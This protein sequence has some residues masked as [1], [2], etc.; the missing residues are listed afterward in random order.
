MKQ[1]SNQAIKNWHQPK[2]VLFIFLVFML[3]LIV[4]LSYLSLSDTIYGNDLRAFAENRATVT[5]VLP[6][7]RGTIYDASG[8]PLALNVTSYTLYAYLEPS[9]TTNPDRPN[10]VV[11]IERT[12]SELGELIGAPYEYML[13]RLTA[14]AYQV[15][16]GPFGSRLTEL[17]MLSIKALEL[18]GI[19][20]I[21][22]SKRF[23]PNGSF[24]S[25]VLGYARANDDGVIV[26]NLGIESRYNNVL[27]GTN[28]S[29]TYQRDLTGFQIPETPVFR[30]D[31]IN[32]SDIYLTL[33]ATIQRFLES[34]VRD[35]VVAQ[36]PEWMIM[37]VMDAKTGAILGSATSPTFDPNNLKPGM[38][39]LSPLHAL[40][41]EP[42]SVMKT[43]TYLCAL[44]TGRYDGSALFRSGS[45]T[46]SGRTINDWRPQG[47]GMIDYDIGYKWS[48]NVGSMQLARQ[49]LSPNEL[50][51]CFSKF[52][53]GKP[54]GIELSTESAGLLAFDGTIE[55]D[56]LAATYGQGISTTPVQLLQALT[57]IANDGYMI[58]PHLISKIVDG[59]TGEEYRPTISR[60]KVVSSESAKKMRELMDGAVNE[61]G[62]PPSV[63][64]MEDIRLI[65]KTGTAQI[66]CTQ[67]NRYLTGQYMLSFTGM[68]PAEDPEIIFYV[69]YSKPLSRFH[70]QL[71]VPTH[72]VIRN[73]AKYLNMQTE[74]PFESSVNSYTMSNYINQN[75]TD[76]RETLREMGM[77]VVVIGDGDKVINQ[78]PLIGTTVVTG[79]R[80]FL[81]TNG[82]NRT[83]EN[84]MGWTRAEFET[85]VRLLGN[86]HR[87][88]GF[89]SVVEQTIP[90]G[91][92]IEKDMLIEVI[93]RSR[94]EE[95]EI[96]EE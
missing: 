15:E 5:R 51:D 43:F 78:R 31:A 80:I 69:A 40:A 73:I 27:T 56:W 81:V 14:D 54:T 60:E 89:G 67:T 39:Y 77:R 9:R 26:G 12:A 45:M 70:R 33:D 46:V 94:F 83:M 34:A 50:R 11:D 4:R 10:H 35:A 93:L 55:I 7:K 2:I 49:L 53:F 6:A 96:K 79:D 63:F 52:G 32:G 23:Y 19:G 29:I 76:V 28:G 65:G 41:Y 92:P 36:R 42:G 66:W 71:A 86:Q 22:S 1:E 3:S 59:E 64:H 44:E 87:I 24:A 75:V 62:F 48:S 90:P 30:T 13:S 18:P 20:F 47:W 38:S 58:R 25:Y 82:N 72:E 68:F 16:F 17:R 37:T 61:P 57:V 84:V 21:E 8:N 91:T 88:N 95:E 74:A 85:Y